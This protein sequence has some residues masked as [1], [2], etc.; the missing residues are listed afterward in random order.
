MT[1]T[2]PGLIYTVG[3]ALFRVGVVISIYYGRYNAWTI[4]VPHGRGCRFAVYS[5]HQSGSTIESG[6][7]LELRNDFSV[8]TIEIYFTFCKYLIAAAVTR[9]C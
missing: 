1:D 4:W 7:K 8:V 6:R 3:N 9:L 5:I 2:G